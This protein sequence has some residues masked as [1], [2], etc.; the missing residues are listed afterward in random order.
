MPIFEQF[1]PLGFGLTGNVIVVVRLDDRLPQQRG[2]MQVH[3]NVTVDHHC[4]LLDFNC[5][6]ITE[7]FARFGCDPANRD[8]WSTFDG[9][10]G[11]VA[12]AALEALRSA[13]FSDWVSKYPEE[14]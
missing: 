9:A 12:S 7:A 4:L 2:T 11:P 8:Y 10:T 3:V 6:T 14:R 13:W 5:K 1:S